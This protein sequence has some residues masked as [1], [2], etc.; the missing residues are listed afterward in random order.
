MP[1]APSWSGSPP[2]GSRVVLTSLNREFRSQRSTAWGACR[3][4]CFPP[5]PA[6]HLWSLQSSS[7]FYQRTQK[8]A[9]NQGRLSLEQ[10]PL[11]AAEECPHCRF[12]ATPCRSKRGTSRHLSANESSGHAS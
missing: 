11:C 7:V 2:G 6:F 12:A 10:P 5:V 4:S 3:T 1:Q 9:A 8:S